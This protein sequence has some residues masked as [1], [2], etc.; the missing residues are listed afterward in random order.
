MESS[1]L[2]GEP[3]SRHEVVT[4]WKDIVDIFSG[5]S[6]HGLLAL[7]KEGKLY[8]TNYHHPSDEVKELKGIRN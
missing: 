1:K 5:V 2:S 7:D 3:T 8:E 6:T 4:Q